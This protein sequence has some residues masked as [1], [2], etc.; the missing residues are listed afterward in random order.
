MNSLQSF[1]T[2]QEMDYLKKFLKKSNGI[3]FK[4]FHYAP[5]DDSYLNWEKAR[6]GWLLTHHDHYE[7]LKI[8]R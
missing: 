7:F 1:Y 3:R 8:Y 6:I 4:C 5:L 2:K